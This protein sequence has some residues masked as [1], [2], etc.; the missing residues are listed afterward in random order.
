MNGSWR[1]PLPWQES[2][3][4]LELGG[5]T[6]WLEERRDPSGRRTPFVTVLGPGDAAPGAGMTVP[7]AEFRGGGTPAPREALPQ[8]ARAAVDEWVSRGAC[9]P[10]ASSYRLLA[11]LRGDCDYFLASGSAR[12]SALWAGSAAAQIEKM[13]DLLSDVPIEP[14]WLTSEDLRR[15]ATLM[16]VGPDLSATWLSLEPGFVGYHAAADLLSQFESEPDLADQRLAGTTFEDWVAELERSGIMWRVN[17]SEEMLLLRKERQP[18]GATDALLLSPLAVPEAPLVVARSYS[19]DG[20]ARSFEHYSSTS[21]ALAALRLVPLSRTTATEGHG[22]LLED[23]RRLS[24]PAVERLLE[25]GGDLWCPSTGTL[26]VSYLSSPKPAVAVAGA[27]PEIVLPALPAALRQARSGGDEEVRLWD[28]LDALQVPTL[29][30]SD[31]ADVERLTEALALA[32]GSYVCGPLGTVER[33]ESAIRTG[34]LDE[35]RAPRPLESATEAPRQ[36]SR[37]SVR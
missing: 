6:V 2:P 32:G 11:R 12:D 36:T 22:I 14:D 29:V 7:A 21:E 3:T 37:R 23:G 13:R 15:L 26:V 9:A 27:P 35:L 10:Y 5:F 33:V 25:E 24:A 31:P 8:D 34:S 30:I 18:S 16:G 28:V 1:P 19:A 4:P 17:P 20:S